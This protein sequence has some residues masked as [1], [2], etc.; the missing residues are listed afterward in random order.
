M[1]VDKVN[2]LNVS[3]S[4][5]FGHAEREWHILWGCVEASPYTT[6]CK[7]PYTCVGWE[8]IQNSMTKPRLTLYIEFGTGQIDIFLPHHLSDACRPALD[9]H[10]GYD[11]LYISIRTHSRS[12]PTCMNI[13]G[14]ISR[15]PLC[16]RACSD[17][18]VSRGQ[19]FWSKFDTWLISISNILTSSTYTSSRELNWA[20]IACKWILTL[21]LWF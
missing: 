14:R 18:E 11:L 16:E 15:G 9:H 12:I 6:I 10:F 3:W 20:R 4:N 2:L 21:K 8:A 13:L 19:I 17:N 1:S 5:T 7:L